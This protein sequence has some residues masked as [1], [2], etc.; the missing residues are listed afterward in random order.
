MGRMENNKLIYF[1]NN[2]E[3]KITIKYYLNTDLKPKISEFGEKLYPLYY[4]IIVKSKTT[5][6]RSLAMDSLMSVEQFEKKREYLNYHTVNELHDRLK[7]DSAVSE[8]DITEEDNDNREYTSWNERM[9]LYKITNELAP[10]RRAD[11]DL[12]EVIE[13]YELHHLKVYTGIN[14]KLNHIIRHKL[15]SEQDSDLKA[16]FYLKCIDWTKSNSYDLWVIL[17]DTFPKINPLMEKYG[18]CFQILA[19]KNIN[20]L[21]QKEMNILDM[22][23]FNTRIKLNTM[24]QWREVYKDDSLNNYQMFESIMQEIDLLYFG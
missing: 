17:K 19:K 3:G 8:N 6:G 22:V 10:F 11:F 15:A 20:N 21:Q 14:K 7:K 9:L 16:I 2:P 12:K 4:Q 24:Y 23:A 13:S 5:R 18:R 1:P